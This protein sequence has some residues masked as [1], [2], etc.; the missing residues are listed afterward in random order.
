MP[1]LIIFA[2]DCLD[3]FIPALAS[4]LWSPWSTPMHP[5]KKKPV[6]LLH[7]CTG[8][9]WEAGLP[10]VGGKG[11]AGLWGLVMGRAHLGLFC[12]IKWPQQGE[13]AS[14]PFP[15]TLGPLEIL[16][17]QYLNYY[18]PAMC[19]KFAHHLAK[20]Q[21]SA[22]GGCRHPPQGWGRAGLLCAHGHCVLGR[23]WGHPWYSLHPS[24]S[25]WLRHHQQTHQHGPPPWHVSAHRPE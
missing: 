13:R 20:G 6:V 5:V 10:L 15:S 2:K 21:F 1:L 23:A 17:R 11:S 22:I 12:G 14:L 24:G 8:L 3:L 18:F 9:R 4:F 25:L 16:L 19:Y 7:L